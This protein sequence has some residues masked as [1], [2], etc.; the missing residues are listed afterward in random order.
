[1]ATPTPSL[2]RHHSLL[3]GTAVPRQISGLRAVLFGGLTVGILDI[4]DAIVF[5]FLR[6]DAPPMRILQSVAAGLLGRQA[7]RAGGW[8]TALLGLLLH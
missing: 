7:A 6:A 4:T 8:P 5:W 2:V 3:E 1:M